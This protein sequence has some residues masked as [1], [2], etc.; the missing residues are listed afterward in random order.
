MRL[1]RWECWCAVIAFVMT[2]AFVLVPGPY[3]MAIFT[4]L[5]QPLF[6]FAA[7]SYLVKVLRDLRE[8][9]AM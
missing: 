9:K 6:A 3:E 4:F 2:L 7:I 1:L 8:R 5:A